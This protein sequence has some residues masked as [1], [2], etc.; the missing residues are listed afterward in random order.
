MSVCCDGAPSCAEC[1]KSTK[2]G[3]QLLHLVRILIFDV[4]GAHRRGSRL[5]RLHRPALIFLE[6]LAT[7]QMAIVP[8]M[9][10]LPLLCGICERFVEH[11]RHA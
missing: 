2:H 1:T 10:T 3:D 8:L 5:Q 6:L 7:P 9:G 4:R 11:L